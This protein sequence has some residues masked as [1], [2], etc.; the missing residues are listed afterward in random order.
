MKKTIGII[1]IYLLFL[2]VGKHVHVQNVC[3]L[4]DIDLWRQGMSNTNSSDNFYFDEM[5]GTFKPSLHIFLPVLES[6]MG[7]VIAVCPGS[8]WGIREEGG[9]PNDGCNNI[10]YNKTINV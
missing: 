4:F 8:G 9:C 7:R 1:S 10:P 6:A 3:T 5:K 2:L